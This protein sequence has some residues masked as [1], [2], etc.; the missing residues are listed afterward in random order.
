M[1]T[2]IIT[3]VVVTNGHMSLWAP[4]RVRTASDPQYVTG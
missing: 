3:N 2:A 1:F 4:D